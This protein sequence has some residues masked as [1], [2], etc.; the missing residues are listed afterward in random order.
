MTFS[1]PISLHDDISCL[2]S[3]HRGSELLILSPF[4]RWANEESDTWSGLLEAPEL[5][6]KWDFSLLLVT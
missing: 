5:V 6:G 4:C 3:F 1:A 2:Q